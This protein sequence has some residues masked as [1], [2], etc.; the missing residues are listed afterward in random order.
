VVDND[1]KVEEVE[2]TLPFEPPRATH[3]THANTP[4]TVIDH[5]T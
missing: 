1:T 5:W 4:T 3:A 2:A